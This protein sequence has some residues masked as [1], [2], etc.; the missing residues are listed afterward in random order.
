MGRLVGLIVNLVDSRDELLA[1]VCQLTPIFYFSTVFFRVYKMNWSGLRSNKV[2]D[3]GDRSLFVMKNSIVSLSTADAQGYLRS[4][5]Y[6]S[7]NECL[8][9]CIYFTDDNRVNYYRDFGSSDRPSFYDM[10][11]R[12]D[13]VLLIEIGTFTS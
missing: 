12:D 1:V 11:H 7:K 2:E 9:N 13:A 10:I 6:M 5:R 4:S 3:L 8:K